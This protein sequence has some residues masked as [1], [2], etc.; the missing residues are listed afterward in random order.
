MSIVDVY[1]MYSYH[2]WKAARLQL[3]FPMD[4]NNVKTNKIA[5]F[6]IGFYVASLLNYFMISYFEHYAVLSFILKKTHASF[7]SL[8]VADQ[9]ALSSCT[10]NER[11]FRL[12]S[13]RKCCHWFGLPNKRYVN[14]R[15]F[16]I[17]VFFVLRLKLHDI[18]SIMWLF[19]SKKIWP[20]C[21]VHSYQGF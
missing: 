14:I 2:I 6:F 20:L 4:E 7:L 3:I 5:H 8:S 18:L 19:V 9:R 16:R 12:L 21:V 11:S 15:A 13:W 10:W 17:M 1:L